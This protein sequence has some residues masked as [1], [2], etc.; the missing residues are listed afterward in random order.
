[1][2]VL[3]RLTTCKGHHICFPNEES[4]SGLIVWMSLVGIMRNSIKWVTSETWCCLHLNLTSYRPCINNAYGKKC[5]SLLTLRHSPPLV[6]VSS[7]EFLDIQVTIECGFTLKCIHDMIKTYSQ[8]HRRDKYSQHSPIIWPVWLNG[9]LVIYEL[10]GCGFKAHC[11]HM[12]FQKFSNVS[13][14]KSFFV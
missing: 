11:S 1:M 9:W 5:T 12:K 4:L 6:P 8:M 3:I 2:I 13:V 10:S 7:K 14:F